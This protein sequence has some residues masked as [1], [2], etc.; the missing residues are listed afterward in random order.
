[1]ESTL[2]RPAPTLEFSFDSIPDEMKQTPQWCVWRWEQ[3][4]SKRTKVPYLGVRRHAKA[5]SPEK[6]YPY[7]STVAMFEGLQGA[8]QPFDG[9]GFLFTAADPYLGVD[10]DDCRDPETGQ[11]SE[12]AQWFLKNFPTYAEISPSGTGIKLI[13]RGQLPADVLGSNKSGRKN[14]KRK[15]ET[16]D[17]FRFFT[18]TGRVVSQA[19]SRVVDCQEAIDA[20]FPR[21]FP[22]RSKKKTSTGETTPASAPP[23]VDDEILAIA[24]RSKEGAKF[25]SLWSGDWRS[26]YS[27]QSEADLALCNILAFYCGQNSQPLVDCLFRQSGLMRD[28]WNR[29]DYRNGT[30]DAAFNRSEFYDRSRRKKKATRTT[31]DL[32]DEPLN[33]CTPFNSEGC[34]DR[35]HA[36]RL[37]A[38]ANGRFRFC[39]PWGKWLVWDK[40]RWVVD[41]AGLAIEIAKEYADEQWAWLASA[42]TDEQ[43]EVASASAKKSAAYRSLLSFLTLASSEPGIPIQPEHLDADQFLLNCPNGTVDLRSGQLRPHAEDDC[44]TKLC[45]T[46]YEPDSRSEVWSKFVLSIFGGDTELAEHFQRLAGYMLTGDVSEQILLIAFGDGSNGKSTA[47][48]CQL[49]VLGSDYA[50]RADQSLLTSSK[51]NGHSTERM[52]LFGKRLAVCSETEDGHHLNESQVKDLTGSDRIRGRRMRE[53]SWEYSPTHKIVMCTNHRPE[54]SGT[55][56]GIWRRLRLIPFSQQFWSPD[57]GESGPEHLKADKALPTKLAGEHKGILAWMVKGCLMWQQDGLKTPPAVLATTA[58]YREDADTVGR[59][60]EEHCEVGSGMFKERSSTLYERFERWCKQN[61]EPICPCKAFS[62]LLLKRG[63][64]KKRSNGIWFLRIMLKPEYEDLPELE[65]LSD[66]IVDP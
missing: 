46:P 13:A 14:P 45:P 36:W 48:N 9:I 42:E 55:D 60:I 49:E 39:H 35:A 30:L 31:G 52:D 61:S 50:I 27:S 17:R 33:F 58:A 38:F 1:M 28:K 53:D 40:T 51:M 54:V 10:V 62:N 6:W 37:A 16:Y 3:R 18:V 23:L 59:F 26:S 64:E 56:H 43:R 4:G 24:R 2:E 66:I 11:L 29:D 15:I 47:L 63:Y 7:P 65:G 32:P 5:D 57:N 44:I 41:N 12:Q 21:L 8:K 34:T 22:R 19:H 20:T 25:E